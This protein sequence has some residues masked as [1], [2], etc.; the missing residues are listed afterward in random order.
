MQTDLWLQNMSR[1]AAQFDTS[2]FSAD[3]QRQFFKIKDIGTAALEDVAKL[4]QVRLT[5]KQV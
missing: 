3:M 2:S 5:A 1:R 4:E